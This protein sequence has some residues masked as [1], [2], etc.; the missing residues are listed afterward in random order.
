MA[1]H[2]EQFI[3]ALS[4]EK[5]IDRRLWFRPSKTPSRAASR[6]E[7]QDEVLRA[8]T[9]R[10]R[11]KSA[12]LGETIVARGS[13]TRRSRS[14]GRM[15]SPCTGMKAQVTWKWISRAGRRPR[16]HRR[17]DGPKQVCFQKVRE[18]E[19][20]TCSANSASAAASHRGDRQAGSSRADDLIRESPLEARHPAQGTSRPRNYSVASSCGPSSGRSRGTR[21]RSSCSVAHDP[22]ASSWQLFEAGGPEIYRPRHVVIGVRVASRRPGQGGRGF[23]GRDVDPV[24]ACVGHE[25]RASRPSS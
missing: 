5:G 8:A 17:A 12:L 24:G 22:A 2:C 9:T 10:L 16:T 19:R 1:S 20:R 21:A 14:L 18:A 25:G 13:R 3:D 6:Q 4:K 7:I 23:A 11:A 15:R